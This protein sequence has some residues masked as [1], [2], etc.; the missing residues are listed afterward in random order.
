MAFISKVNNIFNHFANK[1]LSNVDI[2]KIPRAQ[3]FTHDFV[4]IQNKNNSFYDLGIDISQNLDIDEAI[5]ENE[6]EEKISFFA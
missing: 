3:S 1:A 2:S 5:N 4:T 6:K